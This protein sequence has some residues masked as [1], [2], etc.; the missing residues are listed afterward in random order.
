M[1]GILNRSYRNADETRLVFNLEKDGKKNKNFYTGRYRKEIACDWKKFFFSKLEKRILGIRGYWW[2]HLV[3]SQNND[4][5]RNRSN[6]WRSDCSGSGD[7]WII[8]IERLIRSESV[9]KMS[10]KIIFGC[11]N[12]SFVKQSM[13]AASRQNFRKK[14]FYCFIYA[15][16]SARCEKYPALC[17]IALQHAEIPCAM[18]K[19]L[20]LLYCHM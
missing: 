18:G 6:F 1:R 5:E 3:W 7:L 12:N 15:K 13:L 19:S 10:K 20:F 9:E 2:R 17:E 8:I 14:Y 4:W 16:Y 11:I